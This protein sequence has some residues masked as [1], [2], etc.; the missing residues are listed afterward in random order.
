MTSNSVAG[1][2]QSSTPDIIPKGRPKGYKPHGWHQDDSELASRKK[3]LN[4]RFCSYFFTRAEVN[5]EGAVFMCCPYWLPVI[6]GDLNVNTM[7]E[8]WN[9]PKAQEIRNQLYDGRNWPFCKHNT[10]P[11][12]QHAE[13]ALPLITDVINDSKKY[14]V[15]E[16]IAKSLRNKS[17]QANYLPHDIQVGT[18]ES[19]NLYCP[20]CRNSKIIHAKGEKYEQRKSLTDKLFDEILA[21]PKDYYFDI[22]IT[23][24]GDPFGSKIFRERLQEMDLTD[25]PNTWLNFQTNGV[26]LTPKVWDSIHKIHNQIKQI[27]FSFDAGRKETYEQQTR[28]GGHWDQLVSN[29]DYVY[30]KIPSFKEELGMSSV[31]WTNKFRAMS[32]NFVVQTCNYREIPEFIQMVID[33]WSSPGKYSRATFSLI[34]DWGH[35]PDFE[36]RAIWKPSHPEH[37]NFLQVLRD[38]IVANAP[39]KS[40]M[41]GNMKTLVEQA[42]A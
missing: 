10:C 39:A 19:C 27:V 14:R 26:M 28:L 3:N 2:V 23:G 41:F 35:M 42:N 34:V 21:A 36:E 9:G 16:H 38:P 22:W 8:I 32:H 15:D 7:E 25:R 13:T 20:S 33:R 37:Q 30:N 4:G 40:V 5:V 1:V 29:V 18:D 6:V 31:S 24:G 17:P 11:K 12:I